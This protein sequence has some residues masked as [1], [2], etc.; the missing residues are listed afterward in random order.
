MFSMAGRMQ[1][2]PDPSAATISRRM[3]MTV[4]L[5]EAILLCAA[6]M[7]RTYAGYPLVMTHIAIEHDH[8]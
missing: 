8:L 2:M 4:S 3:A 7:K 5:R 6:I 1:D